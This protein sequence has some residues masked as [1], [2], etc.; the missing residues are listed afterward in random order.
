M[1]IKMSDDMRI[2]ISHSPIS[3]NAN[4][5]Y[6]QDISME[7]V[8]GKPKG[9]WYGFGS[10]WANADA[11]GI[12]KV[13]DHYVYAVDIPSGKNILR[14]SNEENIIKFAETFGFNMM[15]LMG[16]KFK[17]RLKSLGNSPMFI[18]IRWDIIAKKYDGIEFNPYLQNQRFNFMWYYGLDASSGCIWNLNGVSLKPI[19]EPKHD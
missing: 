2:V 11:S 15:E 19:N 4:K 18:R 6:K 1:E 16:N 12:S 13:K 5:R 14:L 8:S 17:A 3:L 10:S 9:L 7:N